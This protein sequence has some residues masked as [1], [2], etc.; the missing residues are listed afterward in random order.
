MPSVLHP[1]EAQA[2]PAAGAQHA[3][4]E[5]KMNKKK[6][7]KTKMKTTTKSGPLLDK[8][9]RLIHRREWAFFVFCCCCWCILVFFFFFSFCCR[10]CRACV[11]SP[12]RLGDERVF[13]LVVPFLFSAC[14]LFV[15]VCCCCCCF[16]LCCCCCCCR[17]YCN[18]F[19]G[20]ARDRL[21]P[22][23]RDRM[24]VLLVFF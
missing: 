16:K 9:C 8:A 18:C 11:Y 5:H 7:K 4:K 13:R 6:N 23:R 12:A 22:Y 2:P 15:L 14:T 24:F 17:C 3:R 21:V 19:I 1:L 10:V 20:L